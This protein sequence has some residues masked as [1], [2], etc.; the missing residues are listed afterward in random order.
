MKPKCIIAL[1]FIPLFLFFSAKKTVAKT[2]P[3]TTNLP[4]LSPIFSSHMVLQRN[5]PDPIWGWSKPVDVIHVSIGDDAATAT[6]GPDG[7]WL[8][9]LTPPP[10]GGPYTLSITGPQTIQLDDILV[11]DVW[12]CGGQSNMEL[13]LSDVRD[14]A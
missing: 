14:G 2:E 3:N 5:K 6:A 7:R 1:L 13:G 11:G 10:P 12:L 4:F 8:A 9:N